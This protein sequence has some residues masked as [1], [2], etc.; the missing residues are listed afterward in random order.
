MILS[1]FVILS[2][3]TGVFSQ[4]LNIFVSPHP[5][6][7]QLFMNPN[8]YNMLASATQKVV[9]LHM[10]TGDGGTTAQESY[11][12]A[13]EEESMRA[14]RF[15]V[16]TLSGNVGLGNAMSLSIVTINGHPIRK[17]VYGNAITYFLRL[18]DGAYAGTGYSNHNY[19]SL[20]NIYTGAVPTMTTLDA[21][22]TYSS[23]NDLETTLKQ[24]VNLEKTAS[25]TVQFHVADTDTNINPG[26]H[27]DHIASSRIMQDVASQVGT[28]TLNLYQE[29]TTTDANQNVFGN[30]Y[31]ISIATWGATVSGLTDK[32]A[33]NPWESYHNSFI[34]KQYFRVTQIN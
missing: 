21:S 13:R 12:L 25:G 20:Q 34:G 6:D 24:I 33:A 14:I 11:Y 27:P 32:N 30:D 5:D 16:N 2:F 1:A 9:F 26:D 31:L 29:Y 8:A 15:M 17:L 7:W 3:I 28:V 10:T 23:L 4:T 18:P 22:T 19:E